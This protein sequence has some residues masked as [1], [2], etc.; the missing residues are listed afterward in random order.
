L[1]CSAAALAALNRFALTLRVV[2]GDSFAARRITRSIAA[3]LLIALLALAFVAAWRFTPPPRA[4]FA[5]T[6]APVHVHIHS[7]VEPVAK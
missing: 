4:L 5:A 3:E 1:G 7:V 2:A 6:E